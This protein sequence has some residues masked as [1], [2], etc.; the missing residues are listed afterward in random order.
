MIKVTLQGLCAD[1]EQELFDETVLRHTTHYG[2]RFQEIMHYEEPK[3]RLPTF[4]RGRAMVQL[5]HSAI[6]IVFIKDDKYDPWHLEERF[7]Q[8]IDGLGNVY[9]VDCKSGHYG[10]IGDT[11]KVAGVVNMPYGIR[12]K[13]GEL[14]LA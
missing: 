14:I 13:R 8:M 7:L 1:M 10:H 6:Q 4:D 12:Q 2:D 3:I 5:V 9:W 11:A